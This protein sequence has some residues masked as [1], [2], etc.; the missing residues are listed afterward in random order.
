MKIWPLPEVNILS[1]EEIKDERLVTV[2]ATP[3]AWDVV[4]DKVSLN[5]ETVIQINKATL[6]SWDELTESI[7]GEVIYAVGGGLAV[8]AAK[9]LAKQSRRSL[10]CIP[11]AIS[12]DAIMAWSSAIRKEGCVRYIETT[13]PEKLLVDFDLIASAPPAIRAAGICDVLSIATGSWDWQYA[14]AKG[15]NPPS[16]RYYPYAEKT[17]RGILEGVLD[18]A[19][20]AGRGEV[21]G[22]RQL[23]DCI[24]LE[25]QLLNQLGHARPEEGSEHYFAYAVENKVGHGKAHAELVCPGILIMATLQGQDIQP[26]KEAM[27]SCNIPLDNL[28]P[29]IIRETLLELPEYVR[30]HNFPYGIAHEIDAKVVADLDISAILSSK[31]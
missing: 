4:K 23:L 29:Q 26:L 25:T 3:P 6:E 12:V 2:V 14:E 17:A 11:T 1:L 7:R 5:V 15:Q 31:R 19:K 24:A 8:D 22:L 21:S 30:R 27:L 20:S 9:Y 10:L 16:M 28:D 13:I 18:C